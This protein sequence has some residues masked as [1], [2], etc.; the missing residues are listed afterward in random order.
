M[1]FN[2]YIF[3][4]GFFPV[5]LAGFY[6]LGKNNQRLA[7]AWL[8]MASLVFYGW[9]NPRFLGLIS[10]SMIFNYLTGRLLATHKGKTGKRKIIFIFGVAIN[11]LALCYYKYF[12]FLLININKISDLSLT[13]P[14]IILPLGISFFTFTQ[15]AFL[16]DVY[17]QKSDTPR[18]LEYSLFVT[19]FPHLIAG[20]I[21]HH[22]E[23]IPQFIDKSILRFNPKNMSLGLT[24]FAGGL[25]KKVV[26]ADEVAKFA[27][28]LFNAASQ[29]RGL[30]FV[31][32][33]IAALSYSFQIYLDFS[34]Y[35]DMAC[36]LA[37]MLN[38]KLPANFFSPYKATNIIEFW[39]RWHMTLSRFLRDYLYIPLGGNR[40]GTFAQYRNIMIT[41]FLGGLWHG[42]GWTFILWGI[43]HGC[44]LLINHT[45]RSF[46]SH[47]TL[48]GKIPGTA[49]TFCAVTVAWV[50][51]RSPTIDTALN[52]IQ[53]MM[54]FRGMGLHGAITHSVLDF[55][56]RMALTWLVLLAPLIFMAPNFL[57]L[58]GIENTVI[59]N[60]EMK[61]LTT[62]PLISFIK[63]RPSLVWVLVTASLFIIGVMNLGQVSEFLYF[64]F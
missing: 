35:C 46:H 55:P 11:L 29:G 62:S 42:A 15:L 60:R 30:T 22:K 32:S 49:L 25:V 54:G 38:M 58:F 59:N 20:P 41:M 28:P 31:E 61:H 43:L 63:W 39:K 18:F 27:N 48:M 12:G 45:W 44:Y 4:F 51:F 3:I 57:E 56:T 36:A 47:R 52:I 53:G 33:W 2:S 37:L 17:Q 9:W 64:Q 26:L 21:L 16:A 34:A 7:L 13:L 5:V 19:Y 10:V 14:N 8:V 40:Q 6:L 23:M 1:L 50:F 24:L